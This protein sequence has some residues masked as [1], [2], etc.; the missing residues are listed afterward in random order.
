MLDLFSQPTGATVYFDEEKVGQTPLRL[1]TIAPGEYRLRLELDGH[2]LWSSPVQVVAGG[3]EK[4]VA[5]LEKQA[6]N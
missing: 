4:V 6:A 1:T 3:G 2:L 5:I